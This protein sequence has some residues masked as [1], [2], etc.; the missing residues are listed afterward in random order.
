[1]SMFQKSQVFQ[2]IAKFVLTGVG[3]SLERRSALISI[4]PLRP[5]L[6]SDISWFETGNT[7]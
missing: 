5:V 4:T 1:M 6:C 3:T 7:L 2:N